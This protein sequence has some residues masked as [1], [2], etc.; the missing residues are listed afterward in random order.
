MEWLNGV[1]VLERGSSTGA[2]GDWWV[3]VVVGAFGKFLRGASILLVK[4]RHQLR[5]RI[6]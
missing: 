4:Q 3:D 5:V 6:G 2:G 1:V